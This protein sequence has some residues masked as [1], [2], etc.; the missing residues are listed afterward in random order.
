MGFS[1]DELARF[2]HLQ[3]WVDLIAARPAVERGLGDR[4]DEDVHPELLL[5]TSEL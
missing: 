1:D 3:Q 4:Y 2:P 5:E